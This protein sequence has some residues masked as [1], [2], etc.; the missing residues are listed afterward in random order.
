ME[1]ETGDG[2]RGPG[3]GKGAGDQG[4]EDRNGEGDRSGEGEWTARGL[5]RRWDLGGKGDY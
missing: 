4:D 5:G 2:K 3:V 1:R